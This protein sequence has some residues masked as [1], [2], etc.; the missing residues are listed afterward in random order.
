[1]IRCVAFDFDGTLVQSNGIKRQAYYEVARRLGDVSDIVDWAL[2]EC[3]GD[4]RAVLGAIVEKAAETGKLPRPG[5][6]PWTDLLV[7]KYS[8]IC[9]DAIVA[10]PV[11]PGAIEAL[12]A[13]RLQG[14]RLFVNSSTPL[15]PLGAVL[16]RRS[17][18]G[19]FCGIYGSEGTKPGNLRLALSS[20]GAG[21]EEMV[22]VGDN[23]VDLAAAQEVGCHFIG[24][25]NE[26]SDFRSEPRYMLRELSGLDK[27]VAGLS[28]TLDTTGKLSHDR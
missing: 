2:S 13:L 14:K 10:C 8:E 23:E 24:V 18:V 21:A 4:R 16:R 27:L 5:S 15:A 3:S 26:F 22:F 17:M 6:R 25:L 28:D 11:V 19:Y 7:E 20:V 12:D 9:E 1:M